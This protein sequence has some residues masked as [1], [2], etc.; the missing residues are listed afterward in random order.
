[1]SRRSS[2]PSVTLFPF[3]AVLVCT[4]GALIFLLLVITQKI[5]KQAQLPVVA[6]EVPPVEIE[7]PP[8]LDLDR[9]ETSQE[10]PVAEVPSPLP[11]PKEEKRVLDDNEPILPLM[12]GNSVAD[13]EWL[14]AEW[15]RQQEERW[16]EWRKKQQAEDNKQQKFNSEWQ[17]KIASLTQ[18][19]DEQLQEKKLRLKEQTELINKLEQLRE[20]TKTSDTKLSSTQDELQ[21]AQEALKAAQN[22]RYQLQAEAAELTKKLARLQEENANAA[23]ETEIVAYDS[24]N[25]TARKPI[26]IECRQTEI[27]FASE[28][29][30]LS[31]NEL[32]G[33]PS[34]YNPLKAGAEAL[35]KYWQENGEPNQRPYILLVVR[36]AGTTGF[37]VARGL[38][39]ELEHEFGYEL[40]EFDRKIKWPQTDEG[41]M[42][43]CRAAVNQ[44]MDERDR[45]AKRLGGLA[46]L[47]D[48]PLSYSNQQGEFHLPD[49]RTYDSGD[50]GSFLGD[51]KWIPPSRRKD[52]L[53]Q[54]GEPPRSIAKPSPFSGNSVDD[55]RKQLSQLPREGLTTEKVDPS[56]QR[57]LPGQNFQN[58]Q[59]GQAS[60]T[61]PPPFNHANAKPLASEFSQQNPFDQSNSRTSQQPQGQDTAGVRINTPRQSGV[62]GIERETELH[63]WQDRF[64]V[65]EEEP[66]AIAADISTQTLKQNVTRA[67]QQVTDRWQAPPKAYFWKPVLKI[68]IHPGGML[69]Y[70]RVKEQADSWGIPTRVEYEFK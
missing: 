44:V 28:G 70:A 14:A 30:V 41:A 33:F 59:S 10:E 57:M 64:H 36:P 22:K 25:G 5:Q 46:T 66:Q 56:R 69:H 51:N 54:R 2:T 67:V 61:P 12:A 20:Q 11:F 6:I 3:L 45:V 68:V 42:E 23:P 52:S 16:Q 13:N 53:S 50:S 37:Y 7:V 38:L 40:V 34:E 39:S 21:K 18:S 58:E 27:I 60:S 48:G 49:A 63:L 1:M 35:L 19:L 62:I 55:L 47:Y 65:D 29:I 26:L 4:M 43:A 8:E 9:P 17:T 15:E 32:S 24:L 31:A